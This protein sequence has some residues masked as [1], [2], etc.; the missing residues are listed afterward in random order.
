MKSQILTVKTRSAPVVEIDTEAGAA[1]VRF[2]RAKVVR[3]ISREGPGPIVVVDL[4]ANNQVI[5]VEL[6]GVKVFNLPTLLRQSTIRAPHINPAL[7]RYIR[8]PKQ[9][10]Q[11]AE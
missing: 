11:L 9:E 4:D 7:T 10:A 6:I 3:T 2:K 5:G 8:A 1:Y